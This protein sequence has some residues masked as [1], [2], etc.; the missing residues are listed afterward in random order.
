[1]SQQP[2]LS[3]WEILARL[4]HSRALIMVLAIF[5]A[6]V[7]VL[8]A[9]LPG[10]TY[11]VSVSFRPESGTDRPARI[12]SL[13]AEFGIALGGEQ[14]A[15]SPEFYVELIRSRALLERVASR[16]YG[17]ASG[18]SLPL[19]LVLELEDDRPEVRLDRAVRW[20]DREALT[21]STHREAGLVRLGVT[22]DRA[23][24]S[25]QIATAVLEEVD[26]FNSAKRRSRA[27]A[28]RRFLEERLAEVT[29]DLAA[30]EDDLKR[31]LQ[32]NRSIQESPELQFERERLQREVDRQRQL[33]GSIYQALQQ[34]R[35]SEVR[36]TPVITVLQQPYLPVRADRRH[37]LFKLL[38][39]AGAGL[40]LG[41]VL[42]VGRPA[43]P[44]VSGPERRAYDDVM[45]FWARLVRRFRRHGRGD[46]KRY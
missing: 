11:S 10:P 2:Y 8:V 40:I 24:L 4:I 3:A 23:P 27:L 9:Y 28:E 35:L 32:S 45:S 19:A 33:Q 39:G 46:V 41:M 15:D 25:E 18:D 34:A 43:A 22:T 6:V 30:A 31:F 42:A 5:G 13:A 1:M 16:S 36:D 17:L 21:I 44:P 12:S 20:L 26:H 38:A 37:G 7:G 29:T 14:G